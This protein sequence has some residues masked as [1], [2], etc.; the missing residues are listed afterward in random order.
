L[1]K[2][3]DDIQATEL[4]FEAERRRNETVAAILTLRDGTRTT[5]QSQNVNATKFDQFHK[6]ASQTALYRKKPPFPQD[7]TEQSLIRKTSR[8][9]GNDRYHQ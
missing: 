9:H 2:S 7:V 5:I 4:S 3:Q 6:E 8:N 1:A